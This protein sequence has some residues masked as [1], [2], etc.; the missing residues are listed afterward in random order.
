ME[1]LG[2]GLGEDRLD[3]A[4][5]IAAFVGIDRR[6]VFHLAERKL[7]PVG[8]EGG[9]LVASKAALREHYAKLTR[10]AGGQAA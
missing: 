8:K 3:G 9:R 5:A 7:I 1:G 4:D 2:K 6:R 10:G